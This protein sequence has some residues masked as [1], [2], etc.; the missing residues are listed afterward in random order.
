MATYVTRTRESGAV[1]STL[2]EVVGVEKLYRTG[3]LK[4]PALRGVD[5][6]VAVGEMVDGI[7]ER[8][9]D[10]SHPDS[11]VAL[12]VRVDDRFAAPRARRTLGLRS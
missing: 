9:G 5:L 3:K 12:D 2:I 11:L 8:L 6:S 4:Y 10:G 7:T 1:R